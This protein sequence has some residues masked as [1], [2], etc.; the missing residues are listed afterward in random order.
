MGAEGRN[1]NVLVCEIIRAW[2]VVF[3]TAAAAATA[4]R[5]GC[6]EMMSLNEVLLGV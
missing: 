3:A 6:R 5:R 4:T 1:G 2:H